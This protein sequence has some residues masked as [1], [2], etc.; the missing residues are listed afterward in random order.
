MAQETIDAIN[1]MS[2]A[3][4]IKFDESVSDYG[5]PVDIKAPE[6][7]TDIMDLI[8]P[9][10]PSPTTI[11]DDQ[12]SSNPSGVPVASTEDKQRLKDIT[13]LSSSLDFYMADNHS[14]PQILEELVPKYLPSLPSAPTTNLG[15][16]KPEDN[17]YTYSLIDA[18][19]YAIAFCLAG[20][21]PG[22][23]MGKH[24]LNAAGIR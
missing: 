13:S 2:F 24:V 12:N 17:T 18:N 6:N 8:N 11:I 14:Y 22:F 3:G 20:A 7:A 9:K 10:N 4:E 21:T 5:K 15:V 16:C 1:A 19:N 23:P